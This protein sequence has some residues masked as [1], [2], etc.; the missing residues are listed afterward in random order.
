MTLN[1]E[2]LVDVTIRQQQL[3][4]YLLRSPEYLRRADCELKRQVSMLYL[5]IAIIL[6]SQSLFTWTSAGHLPFGAMV[7]TLITSFLAIINC[8]LLIRTKACLRRL[9]DEWLDPEEQ[10]AIQALRLKRHEILI[11]QSTPQAENQHAELH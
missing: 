3:E 6:V 1:E 8:F 9:N 11:Q 7:L 2:S 5:A 4:E 10:Q